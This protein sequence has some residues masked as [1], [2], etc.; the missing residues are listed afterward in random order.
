[1]RTI[2]GH[3]TQAFHTGWSGTRLWGP[4]FK[5]KYTSPLN[6]VKES[7]EIRGTRRE[8]SAGE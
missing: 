8:L 1:M 2:N 3:V 7:R 4:V 5:M 6:R